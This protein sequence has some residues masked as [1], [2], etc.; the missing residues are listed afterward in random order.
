MPESDSTASV[1][2]EPYPF[3]FALA[4]TALVIIDMQRDFVEP[5][6]FGES[7]GNDVDQLRVVIPVLANVLEKAREAGLLVIHTRE[8][9]LPD[10][11][12]C[13]PNKL[14]RSRQIGAGIGDGIGTGT[15]AIRSFAGAIDDGPA[16]CCRLEAGADTGF[17]TV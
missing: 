17:A 16:I 1:P 8:G 4:E 14:W 10:L 2:A 15:A 6:G 3:E 7:L 13:P 12:D 5:G 9:H 11:S